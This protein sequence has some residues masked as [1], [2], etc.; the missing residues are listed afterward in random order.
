MARISELAS[1]IRAADVAYYNTGEAAMEDA[2][3]D[4]LK[5]E[6]RRLSPEHPLLAVVG[7]TP[8]EMLAKVRHSIPMGS[9]DKAMD[10]SEWLAWIKTLPPGNF[11]ASLKMDGGSVSLEYRDGRLV[12]A[13]TRGDGLI[14]EDITTNALQ[15]KQCPK[16]DV[17]LGGERFSG[18]VRAEIMLLN[19]DWK[20]ADPD[21]V[22]NPRNLGNGIARRKDG[23]QAE[24][25]SVFAFRA[26]RADG[27][28]VAANE[29]EMFELLTGAGF[30]VA[31]W[32]AGDTATI[33]NFFQTSQATRAA[34]DFWIDGV[35]VKINDLS[36]QLALGER[37]QRPRGQIALKFPA[38]GVE[39]VLR[40]VELS[41]GHTGAI[42]PTA[43]F[44][45]VQIGGTTVS[46]ALLCN[47]DLIRALDIA[48]GDTIVVYKAGEIIPK[49]LEVVR[50]PENRQGIP[51]PTT[52]PVCGGPVGRKK[53]VHGEE[54]V[55]LYC[56]N[57]ECPAKL[58][59]KIDRYVRSLNILGIGDEVLEALCT[60]H[61]VIDA[62]FNKLD[63]PLLKTPADLY[64][65][66]NQKERLAALLMGGKT[67]LGTKRAEKILA[68]IEAKRDLTIAELIGSLGIDGLGKR[69]VALIQA[70]VPGELDGID[71]W[72]KRKLSDP[73]FAARA[74]VPNLG[75]V[76][77]DAVMA[78]QAL[79][80]QFK[81]NGIRFKESAA[82]IGSPNGKSFCFTGASSVPRKELAAM[83]AA[84]GHTVKSDV[85][86]GLDFLVMADPNS[87]SSKA[88]KARKLGTKCISEEEFRAM[89]G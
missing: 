38:Q 10:Q 84:K 30:T 69:R 81:A 7:A 49:V 79:V 28:P 15:F 53:S 37:D 64:L 32:C 44:D 5:D 13:V 34:L 86:Q 36:V 26:F 35:V 17:L 24:L 89:L 39:T 41:V 20:I 73:V 6:L 12:R 52:C 74:G 67:K 45:P 2:A 83:A 21:L 85:G 55:M 8:S 82:R 88:T 14:G 72:F 1:R 58:V 47:W 48:V 11:V 18:F 75:P 66:K 62:G 4:G 57:D 80:D 16:K 71:D 70:A 27:Q 77:D 76:L 29:G 59:G 54:S 46:S 9:L 51:E 87:G 43:K 33:W 19:K 63:D 78:K 60:H 68:E 40:S 25:L 50:R 61:P 42:I 65:L 56:L 31:P 3:Y 22:S 23:E